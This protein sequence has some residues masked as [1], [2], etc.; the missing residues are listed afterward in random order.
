VA[1]G[2][3]APPTDHPYGERQYNVQ[4]FAGHRWTF[5]QSLADVAPGQWGGTSVAL[6]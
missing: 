4:D 5:T 3:L 6:E 2:I 1:R